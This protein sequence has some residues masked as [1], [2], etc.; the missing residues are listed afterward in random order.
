MTPAL[1]GKKIGMTRIYDE[2]GAV[3]PVTVV[4]A[5]PCPITQ[6]KTKATD[7]YEAVQLAFDEIK[8]KAS[9]QPLIGHTA[10]AGFAPH[11]HFKEINLKAATDKKAGETVQGRHFQR[12]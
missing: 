9:T 5:G 4:L 12:Y 2:K 1:L 10:K 7:G 11:R 8:A 6:V 3:V